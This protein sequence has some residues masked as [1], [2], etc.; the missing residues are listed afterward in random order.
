MSV[1]KRIASDH[2][3]QRSLMDRIVETSGDSA[4][5]KELF[6]EFDAE[7]KAHAAAEE[8]AFYAPLL[9]HSKSTDQSRHSVAEHQE[10]MELLSSLHD[11][12][13]SSPQWLKLFKQLVHDNNHHMEEE[14]DEVFPLAKELLGDVELQRLGAEFD[15]RKSIE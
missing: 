5:R 12:D 4:K 14:E 6:K 2:E 9:K 10:A 3:V 11:T 8:H 15:Q 13:M 1:L 7:F